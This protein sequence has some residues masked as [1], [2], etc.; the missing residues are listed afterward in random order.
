MSIKEVILIGVALAMDASAI[1]LSLGINCSIRREHKIM[2]AI[3]FG[4]FQF[5]LSFLGAYSGMLF[6]TYIASIPNIV[7][8]IIIA[9]IGVMMIK[10][11]METREECFLIK[12]KMFFILGISVS[13]DAL[14]V[15]FTAFHDTKGI[16]YLLLDSITIGII[17]LI[18][19]I[20]AFFLS[21]YARKVK[22]IT[23]YADY[24]GGIILIF[25]GMKMIFS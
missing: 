25:F 24:I 13:I 12:P 21:R 19:S 15:G 20:T 22:F 4:F 2:F 23:Q 16:V 18:L 3:S 9:I 8:G 10:E 7:G 11:G 5:F 17:T 6:E 1:A 14:V